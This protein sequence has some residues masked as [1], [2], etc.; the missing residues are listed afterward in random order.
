[1]TQTFIDSKMLSRAAKTLRVLAH[2]DRLRVIEELRARKHS[3]GELADKLALPQ[4]AISKHLA[5]LK[6]AGVLESQSDCNFRYYSLANTRVLE[7]L[8]CI[9][10]NCSKEV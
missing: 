4:A 9:K 7:I 10:K 8:N 2:P 3:V 6:N 5:L 1:M